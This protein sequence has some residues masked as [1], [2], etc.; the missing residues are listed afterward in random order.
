M[1]KLPNVMS[2]LHLLNIAD[3]DKILTF[4]HALRRSEL[5][6]QSMAGLSL[7]PGILQFGRR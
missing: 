3:L 6:M 1:Q 5:L 2:Y 7:A 4:G